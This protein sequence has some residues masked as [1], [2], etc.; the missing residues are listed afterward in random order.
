MNKNYSRYLLAGVLLLGLT[1]V[2][3]QDTTLFARLSG[4]NEVSALGV[5]NVGDQD[6]IGSASVLIHNNRLCFS[7]LVNNLSVPVAAH[8]HKAV[9]GVNGPVA[10]GLIKPNRGNLGFSH[11]CM[12]VSA[13]TLADIKTNPAN[14]YV[15]VHT[16]QFAGGAVRGQLF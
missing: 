9:A 11:G 7:I 2:Y 16:D 3:A 1:D 8:I 15:N 6:G 14:Y 10:V 5:A 4:G 13:A 12:V